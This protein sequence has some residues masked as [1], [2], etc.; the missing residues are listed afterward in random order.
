MNKIIVLQMPLFKRSYK[1]LKPNQRIA[2]DKAVLEIMKNPA[3]GKQKKGDLNQVYVYKFNCIN[4]L[5]LL[6]YEWEI[7]TRTLLALGVH[8]NFYRNLKQ[9]K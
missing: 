2:T 6:A 3:L 7:E 5:F 9:N 8:E 1:K 4:Q